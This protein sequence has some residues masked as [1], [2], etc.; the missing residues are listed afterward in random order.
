MIQEKVLEYLNQLGFQPELVDESLGYRF[1]YEGLTLIYS[2]D[3]EEAQTVHLLA[4]AIFEVTE[5]NRAEVLEAMIK[6]T[7]KVK[8]IQP[9]IIWDSVWIN[10]QH[11]LGENKLT[12][13][14]LEH[15]VRVL[16]VAVIQFQRIINNEDHDE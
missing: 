13:E 2:P 10:Y 16:D 11:Y 15:M 3:D 14:T 1:E 9:V 5:Q 8:F 4:P 12:L 7:G 6:L